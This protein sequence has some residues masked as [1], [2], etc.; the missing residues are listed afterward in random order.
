MSRNA[1]VA[2]FLVVGVSLARGVGDER[3][4]VVKGLRTD[5]LRCEY[6]VHPLAV[7]SVRPR[8]SWIVVSR[9]REQRQTAYRVLAASSRD[10][11]ERDE[12]DLW[13][14]GKIAS[15]RTTQVV[16]E[17]KPLRSRMRV[18]WKV[19]AWDKD[20]K[21]SPWSEE[22]TWTMGLLNPSDWS[23]QWIE[24]PIDTPS[25]QAGHNGY[26]SAFAQEA[27]TPKWVVIDLGKLCRV[28]SVRLWPARPYD[29]HT[30]I[31]GFLFPVRF[32]ID[33]SDRSNFQ[34]FKTVVDRTDTDF[35]NPG[36]EAATFYFESTEARYVRLN[37]TQ[38][39]HR[40]EE[41]FAF[42]LA[43]MEVFEGQENVALDKPVMAIDC[44]GGT[45][46]KEALTNGLTVPRKRI[47]PERHPAP[48][49]RK[50]FSLDEI[51]E[52]AVVYVSALGLYVL[53]INGE[54]VGDHLLAPEWTDY[55][56]RI[57][58]QAYEVTGLLKRGEN[59]IG[60]ILGDGW[61][62]G[63]IGLS[64]IVEGGPSFG[65]YGQI[66]RMIAQLEME[67]GDGRLQRLVTDGTWRTTLEGP[68]RVNDILDGESVDARKKMPGWDAPGFDDSK[69]LP[70]R[71]AAKVSGRLVSQSNEPI[72]VTKELKPISRAEPKPGVFVYDLGQNMVGWV[73]IKA[74]GE[75]GT[76]MTLRHGEAV[77]ED[78]SLYTAN[79]RGA[80]QTDCYTFAG[81]ER[82]VFEPQ[83]TY[84][85]FRYVEV[86][87]LPA[88]PPLESLCGRVFHS[89]SPIVGQ[90]ESSSP[91][92]N[93]L[94]LNIL[95]T[96]R[97]NLMST[98]TDCPQ[99]D[100]RLGW[101][102][103][104]QVFSQTACFNMDMAGFFTKWI[105]DV[106][107]A[108]ASDGR[109]PD[110]APHPFQPDV[111]F[112]GVPAWGDAGVIVPWRIFQNYGDTRMLVEHLESAKR[113]IET[114]RERNPDLIWRNGRH[115]DYNDWL[116]GDTLDLKDWPKTGGAVPKDVLATAFFAHSTELI[117]KMALVVGRSEDAEKY[118]ELAQE[119]KA[120]FCKAFVDSEG[121]ILGDTQA[122]YALA[123]HFE[124][125]PEAQRRKALDHMV[126]GIDRY[127]GHLSTGIQS[128]I[129]MMLEL[130]R[131]GRNDLAYELIN[132]RTM[133]SWGY[134]IDQGA[135]TI[136]ERWDGWVE[137]R[138]F[139]NPGMN[140]LNHW[141]IGSVGEWMVQVILGIQPDEEHPGYQHFIIRPRP[142]GGLTWAKGKYDSI[143]GSI[144]VD[145]RLKSDKL[146]L[147]LSIPANTSATVYI[148]AKWAGSV[149][150]GNGPAADAQGVR[151]LRMEEE[152]AVFQVASGQYAFRVRCQYSAGA[153]IADGM[154]NSW[155]GKRRMGVD[156]GLGPADMMDEGPRR[157]G[158]KR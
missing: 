49:L 19:R 13:D 100:E 56:K 79:L 87:G 102:G 157:G 72:C 66:P 65:I 71:T 90:F 140:S 106:R 145:W 91:M 122:G 2:V 55:K 12:G 141:A 26:H 46:S 60:A 120:A 69:W 84:H 47:L 119:I 124:L 35:T 24:A 22:A 29:W 128:T 34:T 61:Y 15:A 39:A 129:R 53:R 36:A 107:D 85:G 82:E 40:D 148:P 38:L 94:W 77:Q 62:A 37:V 125:L 58:Y 4:A 20:D 139:Q 27:D 121:R 138:G 132:K 63:R 83:F 116:N 134:S 92:L 54:R 31:P 48:M 74:Q 101:M 80:A 17:G 86:T 73:R 1:I 51:P 8:L 96:Q 57:Q 14:S 131:M 70:V 144:V 150:E 152:S 111:R 67:T 117:S 146:H 3:E 45:W 118:A 103:D 154:T 41:N 30:D 43:Q 16:Y 23:A 136:W 95:W 130:T 104:I 112:S 135:T 114:I 52:R 33:L 10:L 151:F 158:P 25:F 156:I 75:P 78:G 7:E 93:Q 50:A 5:R 32:R 18:W 9:E 98:P 137:G 149:R 59:T 105:R 109:Y 88:P 97:A 28:E 21:P 89:S 155:P 110:F 76:T 147:E 6:L 11:L 44:A 143:R 68:V 42:A 81:K 142:G 127:Q 99:R 123:L 64:S 126:A 133:P 115:N 113:W 108:Q 153:E